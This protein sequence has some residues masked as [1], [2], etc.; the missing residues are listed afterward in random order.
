MIMQG[1]EYISFIQNKGKTVGR[2]PSTVRMVCKEK[3]AEDRFMDQ[4]LDALESGNIKD[5]ALY[6]ESSD[7]QFIPSAMAKHRVPK[8]FSTKNPLQK[9]DGKEKCKRVIFEADTDI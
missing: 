7:R 6:M 3:E 9:Y 4:A 8:T 5:E 1:N 2:G